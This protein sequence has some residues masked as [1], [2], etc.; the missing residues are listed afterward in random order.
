MKPEK[1]YCT[2]CKEITP[3]YYFNKKVK[4]CLLCWH[5]NIKKKL[6]KKN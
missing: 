6:T 1:P 4:F 5:R 2:Y 3:F